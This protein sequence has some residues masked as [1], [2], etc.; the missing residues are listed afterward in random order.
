MGV[1]RGGGRLLEATANAIT[2]FCPAFGPW[3][4]GRG[5]KAHFAVVMTGPS[6][7]VRV[8]V[9]GGVAMEGNISAKLSP[10]PADRHWP[11]RALSVHTVAGWASFSHR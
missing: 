3:G 2:T 10:L 7:S 8:C 4:A 6:G 9:G 1:G 5:I 11:W